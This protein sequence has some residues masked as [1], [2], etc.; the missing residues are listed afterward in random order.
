MEA[1]W[2]RGRAVLPRSSRAPTG[3]PPGVGPSLN[4]MVSERGRQAATSSLTGVPR[5][6]SSP[7]T[8]MSRTVPPGQP[9][10]D[11]VK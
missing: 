1:A 4:R 8:R 3:M 7:Q 9:G 10:A 6:I 11:Q 2:A 5:R